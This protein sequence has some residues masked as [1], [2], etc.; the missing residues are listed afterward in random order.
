MQYQFKTINPSFTN[1]PPRTY[2]NP[3]GHPQAFQQGTHQS[4]YQFKMEK[5]VSS[6]SVKLATGV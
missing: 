5:P 4:T 1:L 3:Q 2:V 6:T